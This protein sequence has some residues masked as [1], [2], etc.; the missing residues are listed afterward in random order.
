MSPGSGQKQLTTLYTHCIYALLMTFLNQVIVQRVL[1]G[2]NYSHAKGG[3]VLAGYIKVLPLFI[4]V[5]PGMIA[6]IL[7]PGKNLIYVD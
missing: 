5:F 1:A 3:C 6:R 7:F 4:L 2:K